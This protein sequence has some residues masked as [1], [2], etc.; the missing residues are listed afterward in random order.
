MFDDLLEFMNWFSSKYY[1]DT[2]KKYAWSLSDV[3]R[4]LR[5]LKRLDLDK[6]YSISMGIIFA[7]FAFNGCMSTKPILDIWNNAD[8]FISGDHDA[9]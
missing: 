3:R 2:G 5:L 6:L 4:I 8:E 1:K 7:D 9:F